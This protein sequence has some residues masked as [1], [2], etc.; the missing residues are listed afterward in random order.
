MNLF[1]DAVAILTAPSS[2]KRSLSTARMN[3]RP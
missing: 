2:D 3:R 1:E